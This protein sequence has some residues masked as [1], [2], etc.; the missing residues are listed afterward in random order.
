MSYWHCCRKSPRERSAVI[1]QAP[2]SDSDVEVRRNVSLAPLTTMKV[3]GNADYF[4]DV[5]RLEQLV[6]I[7]Q[8]ARSKGLPYFI[9]GGGSNMLIS[10]D[11]IDGLVIHN[12]CRKVVVN[13]EEPALRCTVY[14]ESGAAMAGV[15]RTSVRAGLAGL[16][17]AVS[18]PGTVGGAVIGNAGAHGGEVKDNLFEAMVLTVDGE[19][20]AYQATD[21]G[22]Q[23]RRSTLKKAALQPGF[24]PVVLSATF[25]LETGDAKEI[26]STADRYLAHRRSTQPV[27]ASLGSTFMNP[28]GD[29]AGRLIE[30]AG[31]KG[32]RVGG[33]EVSNTHA[34]FLVNP[35]GAGTATA[36]QVLAL[37]RLIQTEVEEKFGIRL[38]REVQLA[39]TW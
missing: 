29:Y 11:G 4:A 31:L 27:E 17:W 33:V 22:Y 30:A 24:S 38:E 32:K 20:I 35:G 16:E 18:V 28:P 25:T 39:G 23:Y 5:G 8:W 13:D 26:R 10:D 37:I 36:S 19:H 1:N 6:S 14:A 15:S 12:R 9:L 34:N 3:G 7:V 2:P 21:F